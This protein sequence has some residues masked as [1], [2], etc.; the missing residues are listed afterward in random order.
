MCNEP[1][2][3]LADYALISNREPLKGVNGDVGSWCDYPESGVDKSGET[4]DLSS[5]G[6]TVTAGPG[7]V[8]PSRSGRESYPPSR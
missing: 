7:E 3:P 4:D 5:P 1:R 2:H 8:R 6:L